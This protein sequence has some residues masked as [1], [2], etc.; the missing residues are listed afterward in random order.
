MCAPFD[1]TQICIIHHTFLALLQLYHSTWQ[2][3][4]KSVSHTIPLLCYWNEIMVHGTLNIPQFCA[5][6]YTTYL[7]VIP[8]QGIWMFGY[9]SNLKHTQ[10]FHCVVTI[11]SWYMADSIYL[12]F[13][14]Q[15]IP[16]LYHFNEILVHGTWNIPRFCSAQNTTYLC[17]LW[18]LGIWRDRCTS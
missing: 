16:P 6:P 12:E 9:T 2:F 4:L 17:V 18:F 11:I 14:A 7:F 10:Y 1:I 8:F 3:R 5:A 15:T 13:V